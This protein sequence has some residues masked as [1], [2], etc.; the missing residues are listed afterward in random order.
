M[1]PLLRARRGT[2]LRCGP[3]P[4]PPQG[5]ARPF[6]PPSFETF[7]PTSVAVIVGWRRWRRSAARGDQLLHAHRAI[8]VSLHSRWLTLGRQ[9][10]CGG[11]PTVVGDPRH[12]PRQLQLHRRQSPTLPGGSMC[13][14]GHPSTC[15]S[16]AVV[17]VS[18]TECI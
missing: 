16:S 4:H 9:V 15:R 7:T 10:S 12:I 8:H 3:G 11:S 2:V 6:R 17:L 14:L 5:C 1:M 13:L 18:T